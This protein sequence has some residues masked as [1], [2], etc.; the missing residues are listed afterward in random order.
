VQQ[1]IAD[2]RAAEQARQERMRKMQQASRR[3]QDLFTFAQWDEI[4]QDVAAEVE[5]RLVAAAGGPEQWEQ[6]DEA[7]R[8]RLAQQHGVTLALVRSRLYGK[9]D[10]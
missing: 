9:D 5:D 2:C 1:A 7:G 3:F 6:L 4:M 8:E 10:A